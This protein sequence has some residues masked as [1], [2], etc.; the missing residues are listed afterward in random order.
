MASAA[1]RATYATIR[2]MMR[3]DLYRVLDIEF[4]SFPDPWT[5]EDMLDILRYRETVALVAMA[6]DV[7]A[8]FIVYSL[9]MRTC[10]EILNIAVA[11]E[12]RRQKIGTQLI[13]KLQRKLCW[14]KRSSLRLNVRE[15]NLPAQLFFRENGFVCVEVLHGVYEGTDESAYRMVFALDIE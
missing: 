7:V 11:P 9:K 2:W 1:K 6:D 14:G 3:P 5:E 10:I 13:D 4:D 8:G 12:F 15:T